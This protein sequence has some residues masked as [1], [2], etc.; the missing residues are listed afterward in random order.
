MVLT[1]LLLQLF[2][3]Y[4]DDISAFFELQGGLLKKYEGK[5]EWGVNE[6]RTITPFF[7]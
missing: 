5:A 7:Y 2:V 6:I 3:G 1:K 4:Y